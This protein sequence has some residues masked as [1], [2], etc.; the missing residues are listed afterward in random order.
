MY[1]KLLAIYNGS[2]LNILLSN[3]QKKMVKVK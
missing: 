2:F 1:P 3:P